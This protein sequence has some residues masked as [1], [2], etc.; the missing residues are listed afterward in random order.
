MNPR[1]YSNLR[2]PGVIT[3]PFGG[4]TRGEPSHP[5]IDFANASGTPIPSFA[6]GVVR[7][8]G[9]TTNGMGNVVTLKDGGGNIHQYGHLQKALVRPGQIVKKGQPIAR[10]G[11]TGNVY[12]PSGGDPSHVDIRI[13][14]AK[15]GWVNPMAY[16]KRK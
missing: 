3:T 8:V 10:M 9:A 1:K 16:L 15:G 13:A 12:S 4:R 2:A 7:A 6:N 14:G 11:A 5:G